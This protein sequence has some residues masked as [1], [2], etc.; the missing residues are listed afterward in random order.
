MEQERYVIVLIGS[1]YQIRT[2][3]STYS[4][5]DLA[6]AN[7]DEARDWADKYGAS[8]RGRPQYSVR[9]MTEAECERRLAEQ[10]E[11]A[12]HREDEYD[13]RRER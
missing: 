3:F 2:K 12:Q 10:R 11:L 6:E 8:L 5:R 7:L 9:V 1:N 4:S 13:R